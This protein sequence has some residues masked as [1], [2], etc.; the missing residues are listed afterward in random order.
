MSRIVKPAK[1]PPP[2]VRDS[3]IIPRFY[4]NHF[5]G[6]DKRLLVYR[7]DIPCRITSTKSLCTE[8]DYFEYDFARQQSMNKHELLLAALEDKAAKLY[9]KL[10]AS[11]P[12]MHDE[13]AFWAMFIASLFIRTRKVREQMTPRL[14]DN[15][16]ASFFG[17]E[18]ITTMQYELFRQGELHSQEVLNEVA[19]LAYKQMRS[20]PAFLHF[21]RI[22]ERIANLAPVV[23]QKSWH[24]IRAA[25]GLNFV[26]SDNPVFSVKLDESGGAYPGYGFAH[27]DVTIML[28]LS[29]EYLFVASPPSLTWQKIMDEPST[30]T[31]NRITVACADRAVFAKR[32][33]PGMQELVDADLNSIIYGQNA[34]TTAPSKTA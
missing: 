30:R 15:L 12:L 26:T 6:T 32:D 5:A 1:V 4:L 2:A 19:S 16:K 3:H 33:V 24:T 13:P 10:F 11:R 9:H 20:N 31:I 21:A 34:Y 28:P 22:E 7:R 8:R 23:A 14:L 17:T 25:P 18:N 29:P 27:E